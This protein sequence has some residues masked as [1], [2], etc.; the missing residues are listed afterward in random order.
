MGTISVRQLGK[1]YKQYRSRW[2]RLA[3]W[4]I[5]FVPAQHQDKWV[6]RD[7][8]FDV[9]PGSLVAIVGKT[10]AGK[11]IVVDA[12]S[13]VLGAR[14]SSDVVRTGEDSAEVE[15]VLD[16]RDD[17]GLLAALD[18]ADL[19]EGG[20]DGHPRR[21]VDAG[22]LEGDEKQDDREEVE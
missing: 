12:L 20:G 5:P 4:L 19:R 14:A 8:S 17:P 7:V 6:L 1:A 13:L 2:A 11:S 16:A 9:E 10:G 3:E 21:D 22:N 15:A 18:A